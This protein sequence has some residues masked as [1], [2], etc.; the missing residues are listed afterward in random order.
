MTPG[1]KSTEFWSLIGLGVMVLAN[2]YDAI[3]VPWEMVQW[4]GGI[5]AVY[6]AGRSH[7]KAKSTPT[8]VPN[9]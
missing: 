1:K 3:S 2:G 7:V 9:A 6:I 5:C 4:Y 8:A